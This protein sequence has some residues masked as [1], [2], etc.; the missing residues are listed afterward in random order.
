MRVLE[1][2]RRKTTG[3]I[4]SRVDCDAVVAHLD[5]IAVLKTRE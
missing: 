3:C 5:L 4:G 2:D 1:A